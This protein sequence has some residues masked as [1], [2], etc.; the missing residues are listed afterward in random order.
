MGTMGEDVDRLRVVR[1]ACR[2][3]FVT[4]MSTRL[5]KALK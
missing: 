2:F 4:V 1:E 3:S 5:S